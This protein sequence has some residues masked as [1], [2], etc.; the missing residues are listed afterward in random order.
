MEKN[1]LISLI[2]DRLSTMRTVKTDEFKITMELLVDEK[3]L[4]AYIFNYLKNL[5]YGLEDFKIEKRIDELTMS[6]ILIIKTYFK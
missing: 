4:K 3:K 5:P 1:Q 6:P 2:D